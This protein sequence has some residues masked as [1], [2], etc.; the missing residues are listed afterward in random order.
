MAVFSQREAAL[1][2]D[3]TQLK[4]RSVSNEEVNFF[5]ELS[6]WQSNCH[7]VGFE[8]MGAGSALLHPNYLQT[9]KQSQ[10]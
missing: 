1:R 2:S 9:E 8:R 7:F 3:L 4:T 6:N 10:R 5:C